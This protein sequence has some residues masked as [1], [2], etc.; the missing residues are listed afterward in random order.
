M[1]AKVILVRH[2]ETAFNKKSGHGASADVGERIRG[3]KD[4][5]LDA[6]GRADANRIAESLKRS[7]ESIE[8]IYSSPLSRAAD[9]ARRIAKVCSA[10]LV[11]S[12][13]LRPWNV[14]HWA[15]ELAADVLPEMKR[16]SQHAHE[17]EAAPG[18]ESFRAFLDRFLSFLIDRMAQVKRTDEEVLLVTHTRNLQAARAWIAAGAHQDMS[19]DETTMNDYANEVPTGGEF[20]LAPKAA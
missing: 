4:I 16:L 7:H 9:T 15:G 10:P 11:L 3:W 1:T 5:P 13:E 8:R 17:D 6:Q 14:G 19:Y 18:G 12:P 2:G 20:V